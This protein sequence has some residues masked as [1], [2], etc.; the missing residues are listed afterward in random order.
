MA[1]KA[2]IAIRLFGALQFGQQHQW[3]GMRELAGFGSWIW[4]QTLGG[5]VCRG[6]PD[7]DQLAAWIRCSRGLRDFVAIGTPDSCDSVSE[8]FGAVPPGKQ[9]EGRGNWFGTPGQGIDFGCFERL[10]GIARALSTLAGWL[11]DCRR[12]ERC[13]E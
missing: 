6:K 7:F 10:L 13:C 11:P 3:R 4:I 12:L 9:D 8:G 2:A 5:A 1:A